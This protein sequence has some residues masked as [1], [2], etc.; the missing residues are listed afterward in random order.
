MALAALAELAGLDKVTA[1]AYLAEFGAERTAAASGR[2]RFVQSH[3]RV[4]SRRCQA[5][6]VAGVTASTSPHRRRGISF[7]NAASHSR[8]AGW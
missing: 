2:R 1:L 3:L 5:T 4:T 6:S 8:P 7:D